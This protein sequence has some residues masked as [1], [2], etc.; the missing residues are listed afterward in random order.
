[1][2]FNHFA[3]VVF[4]ERNFREV[5]N[6]NFR[7][8][9]ELHFGFVDF[10]ELYELY[11]IS[12]IVNGI[13]DF[14]GIATRPTAKFSWCGGDVTDAIGSKVVDY[15]GGARCSRPIGAKLS[16]VEFVEALRILAVLG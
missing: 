1:M 14:V 6:L 5:V 3:L 8:K 10:E 12:T 11:E 2:S 7:K 13:D 15:S 16:A 4:T 9:N